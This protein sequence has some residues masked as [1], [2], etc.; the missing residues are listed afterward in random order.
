MP[1]AA[2]Q[3]APGANA[4][5]TGDAIYSERLDELGAELPDGHDVPIPYDTMQYVK[6]S[7]KE[8]V[9]TLIE[10]MVLVFCRGAAVPAE[11][12]RHDHSRCSPCRCR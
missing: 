5:Q 7:I 3:L 2:L 1:S 10:A 4:L 12:A 9:K 6:V 11:L 8:V